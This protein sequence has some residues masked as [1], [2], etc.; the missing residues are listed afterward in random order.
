MSSSTRNR[1]RRTSPFENIHPTQTLE[2]N[3]PSKRT[4]RRLNGAIIFTAA[5]A[6]VAAVGM[7]Y[8]LQT[9]HIAN[10]G[11]EMSQLQQ[12]QAEQ[13]THNQQLTADLSQYQAI[14]DIEQQAARELG[15]EP[16]ASTAFLTVQQPDVA[17]LSVPSAAP[18]D[19]PSFLDK[20][21]NRIAGKG[22]ASNQGS[23]Q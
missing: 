5:A 3:L 8:L 23:R 11:Y 9:N 16:A 1:A 6:L 22:Q 18:P 2:H 13:V 14:G 20:L 7:L 12:E 10:L 19:Q 17:E 4:Q 21:W 15:M